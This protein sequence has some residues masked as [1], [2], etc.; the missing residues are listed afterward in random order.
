VGSVGLAVKN[1]P[2]AAGSSICISIGPQGLAVGSRM[3]GTSAAAS[4]ACSVRTSCTWIQMITERPGGRAGRVPG[5]LEQSR[6]EEE[7]Q[8]RI[9]RRAE[10]PVDGQAQDVSVAT[11][12]AVKVPGA[13]E[14]PAA[15]DV[16][17]TIPASR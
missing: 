1:N 17:V 4:R 13:Q 2:D 11:A 9:V 7:D 12:A 3:T 14:D 6:A 16:H 10:F 8:S 5:D 15:Q